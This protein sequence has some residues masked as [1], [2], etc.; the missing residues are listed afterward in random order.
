MGVAPVDRRTLGLSTTTSRWAPPSG[1]C[2][3][4]SG[5]R[6]GC[7]GSAEELLEFPWLDDNTCLI[8]DVRSPGMSG[9]D[10]QRQCLAA[11]REFPIMFISAHDELV[12][13]RQAL[14]A[15]ALAFLRKPLSE[16]D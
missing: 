9:V 3:G 10:L 11:K 16:E 4:R 13:R 5:S 15:G 12:A 8:M 6:S 14:A 7:V 1:A 2:C